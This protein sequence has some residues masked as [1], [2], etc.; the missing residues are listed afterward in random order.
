LVNY[1]WKDCNLILINP[2]SGKA[3]GKIKLKGKFVTNVSVSDGY[4]YYISKDKKNSKVNYI[5]REPV[6]YNQK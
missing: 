5:Y 6:I 1:N 4:I 2:K 3:K